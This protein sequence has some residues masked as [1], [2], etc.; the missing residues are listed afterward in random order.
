MVKSISVKNLRLAN[1]RKDYLCNGWIS[2]WNQ[3]KLVFLTCIF[4]A[5]I[6]LLKTI[7]NINRRVNNKFKLP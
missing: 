7:E 3:C 5:Q 1:F 2:V 4:C 6:A